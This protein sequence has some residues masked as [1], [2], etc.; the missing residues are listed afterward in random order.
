M[1]QSK[2]L[3]R[4]ILQL[5]LANHLLQK[6]ISWLSSWEMETGE[7]CMALEKNLILGTMGKLSICGVQPFQI[8]TESVFLFLLLQLFFLTT[9]STA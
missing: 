9:P 5:V 6:N 2:G 8:H 4:I 7:G 3:T 1:Q